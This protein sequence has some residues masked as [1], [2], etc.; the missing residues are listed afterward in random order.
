MVTSYCRARTKIKRLPEVSGE[1]RTPKRDTVRKAAALLLTR[2]ASSF[3]VKSKY[4][5]IDTIMGL[6]SDEVGKRRI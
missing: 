4:G 5:K 1:G 2:T 3:M 6:P